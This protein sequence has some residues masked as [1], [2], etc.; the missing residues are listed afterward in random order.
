MDILMYMTYAAIVF[1]A[2]RVFK[3]PV[4][5]WTV[6][7]AFLGGVVVCGGV[8]LTMNYNH[9]ST[10]Q[11]RFYFFTTP[12]MPQVRGLVVEVPVQPNQP[13]KA[14]DILFKI[15]PR[16]FQY[17]V[18]QKKTELAAAK[19]NV[20][21]LEAAVKA[22]EAEVKESEDRRDRAKEEYDRFAEAGA[23]AVSQ[24]EIDNRRQDYLL[25]ED[26]VA[27][28]RAGPCLAGSAA[29]QAVAEQPLRDIRNSRT[30]SHTAGLIRSG[31]SPGSADQ[32]CPDT[33]RKA[34]LAHALL[35]RTAGLLVATRERLSRRRLHGSSR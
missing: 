24:L 19:Q 13:V 33:G 17:A 8:L 22:A 15:D 7:T 25:T 5:K 18:D 30:K 16:P 23:G 32:T 11:A 28:D 35:H 9:P 14:G 1:V 12:I 10:S 21:Q 4:N 20:L 27:R 31:T 26:G 29:S 6:T 34:Q 2:F 3:I